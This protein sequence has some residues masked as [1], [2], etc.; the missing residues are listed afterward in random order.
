M[1][2]TTEFDKDVIVQYECRGMYPPRGGT[3]ALFKRG[4][5]NG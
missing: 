5:G 1:Q 3:C 2:V 4:E